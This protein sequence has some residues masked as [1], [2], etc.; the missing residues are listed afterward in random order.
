MNDNRVFTPRKSKTSDERYAL[1]L[2]A[3]DRAKIALGRRWKAVVTDLV[4]GQKYMA[5]GI[6]CNADCFCD[7][8]ATPVRKGRPRKYTAPPL[9]PGKHVSCDIIREIA[10]DSPEE[11]RDEIPAMADK[12]DARGWVEIGGRLYVTEAMTRKLEA[13]AEEQVREDEL[14]PVPGF[15]SAWER[16]V[17]VY[18]YEVGAPSSSRSSPCSRSTRP[19]LTRKRPSGTSPSRRSTGRSWGACNA[20]PERR[21][22]L[23]PPASRA[24][25]ARGRALH[26]PPPRTRQAWRG[27]CAGEVVR[28]RRPRDSQGVCASLLHDERVG[29]DLQ[30]TATQI[31][32][33]VHHRSWAHVA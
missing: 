5:R 31:G 24:G 23:G 4:T 2:S 21:P 30:R 19:R 17:G 8:V 14:A 15:Y 11:V 27:A 32:R 6:D 1:K 25:Q 9:T 3:E 10:A 20:L 7:A 12:L 26:A 29:R 28:G 33:I 16:T 22:A 13:D 18:E